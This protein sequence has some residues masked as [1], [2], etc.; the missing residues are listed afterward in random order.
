[1]NLFSLGT[2]GYNALNKNTVSNVNLPQSTT[3]SPFKGSFSGSTSAVG[4]YQNEKNILLNIFLVFP[5]R[6]NAYTII[7][8]STGLT[9][10]IPLQV[11]TI[12][13]KPSGTV[14]YGK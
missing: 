5:P 9:T 14:I 1:M 11:T 6:H 2:P 4:R 12:T 8:F 3:F 13:P 7:K 10:Q